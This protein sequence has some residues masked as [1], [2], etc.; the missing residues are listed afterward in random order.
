MK[1]L[2]IKSNHIHL[3]IPFLEVNYSVFMVYA[4]QVIIFYCLLL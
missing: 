4:Y 1:Q 2:W 3:L